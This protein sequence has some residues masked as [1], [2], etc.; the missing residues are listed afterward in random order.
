MIFLC[1]AAMVFALDYV[2]KSYVDSHYSQDFRQEIFG[3]RLILRNH[4]NSHGAFGLFKDKEEMGEALSAG[5]LIG[6]SWDLIRLLFSKGRKLE[7]LGL[8]LAIGGGLSNLYDKKKKGYVNDYVSF[9]V[10]NEKVRNT[11]FNLSDFCIFAG[12]FFYLIGQILLLSK[13]SEEKK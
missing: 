3:G 11:V 10:K 12:A 4:R 13:K 1:L 2:V 8:G 6:I 5:V 7:K 9:P